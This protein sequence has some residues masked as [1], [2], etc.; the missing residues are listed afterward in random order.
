MGDLGPG[1]VDLGDLVRTTPGT[2]LGQ[3]VAQGVRTLLG[4]SVSQRL[5]G[6][7]LLLPP[8]IWAWDL[9]EQSEIP[10]GI[11][12]WVLPG[13]RITLSDSSGLG[14]LRVRGRLRAGVHPIFSP[15]VVP[16]VAF[17]P[18]AVPVIRPEWWGPDD[19][20]ADLDER[21]LRESLRAA[22]ASRELDVAVVELTRS[23]LLHAPVQITEAD[24]LGGRLV[25][26]GT[27]SPLRDAVRPAPSPEFV[28]PIMHR[29]S[30]IRAASDFRV[31]TAAG[32]HGLLE[33]S[34]LS[35]WIVEG[36]AFDGASI[37]PN[38]VVVDAP[39]TVELSDEIRF[40]RCEFRGGVNAS[41]RMARS[42]ARVGASLPVKLRGCLFV[43]QESVTSW[44]F[45]PGAER[46]EAA[47]VVPSNSWSLSCEGCWFYG[48]ASAFVRV[49]GAQADLTSCVFDNS[50][51][52]AEE[53]PITADSGGVDILL[54]DRSIGP[55]GSTAVV[56]ARMCRSRSSVFLARVEAI[57]KGSS[58]MSESSLIHVTHD[59][60][61]GAT[62]PSVYWS[63]QNGAARL[64]L[65]GCTLREHAV[66]EL[67]LFSLK[68]GDDWRVDSRDPNS[69]DLFGVPVEGGGD[70]TTHRAIPAVLLGS[71]MAE[72]RDVGTAPLASPFGFYSV[73]PGTTA[74]ILSLQ[75]N[76]GVW[77]ASWVTTTT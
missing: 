72:V 38:C 34:G 58:P 26:R 67:R 18:G 57:A 17:G 66:K 43:G 7:T 16:R 9:A 74:N 47:V 23:V 45:A 71:T 76:G 4:P 10:V 11:E 21:A 31:P 52:S 54:D 60:A 46:H 42:A 44:A 61:Y 59:P 73:R 62:V 63:G 32:D 70:F 68:P 33:L 40:D 24:A 20:A 22:L 69:K 25:L 48:G 36:V 19:W 29:A 50:V 30:L 5:R 77:N 12:L 49:A 64:A 53:F 2:T 56:H 8:G 13:A 14:L 6:G 3:A 51:R 65:T 27:H 37:A 75:T 39:P 55:D 1:F 15:G 35:R 41:L 28:M